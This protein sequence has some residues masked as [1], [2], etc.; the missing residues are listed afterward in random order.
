MK[1]IACVKPYMHFRYI[2]SPR[3]SLPFLPQTTV[4]RSYQSNWNPSQQYPP[5]LFPHRWPHHRSTFA[6]MPTNFGESHPMP[7]ALPPD[8]D[9]EQFRHVINVKALKVPAKDCHRYVKLLAK[10]VPVFLF[11]GCIA[12]AF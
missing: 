2:T 12:P 7:A 1:A 8:F 11:A 4:H 5:L 9:R 3:F 6:T 10:Y